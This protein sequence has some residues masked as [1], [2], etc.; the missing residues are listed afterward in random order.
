MLEEQTGGAQRPRVVVLSDLDDTLFQTARKLLPGDAARS[1]QATEALNG[2][3]SFMT[4][5]QAEL[6]GWLNRAQVVP[7]T[8]RGA[9]AF[10]RVRLPFGRPAIVANG[11]VI[12][13]EDGPDEVWRARIDAALAPH[14]VRLAGLPDAAQA[15][16]ARLGVRVRAWVVEE[17]GVGG[18][19]AVVKV[20]PCSPEAALAD[21]AP[22]L[23]GAGSDA[24]SVHL[25]GNN[26]AL[27][28]PVFSK[29]AAVAFT[30][31]RM[32]EVGE[33]VAVGYGDSASDLDYMRLCDVWMTPTGSQID[34]GVATAD[35]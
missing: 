25:N 9:E 12:L 7:V 5:G 2:R 27:I 3:H 11:A 18:V 28:P 22:A 34:R 16:A 32:R 8:A 17:A 10:S 26:L 6:L 20:E 21:L 30:L 29:A 13:G 14:R 1:V 35:P 31:A 19:Y 4:P 33:V 24:W 15:A 23:G